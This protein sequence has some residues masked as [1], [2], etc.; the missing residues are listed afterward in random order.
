[1]FSVRRKAE[2]ILYMT[3]F[4]LGLLI[5][6]AGCKTQRQITVVSGKE[7]VVSCPKKAAP[8]AVVNIETVSVTDA[9][10]YVIVDGEEI[11]CEKEGV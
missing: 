2:T 4:L 6:S 3:V 5:G 1:M 11:K 10:L 8:G 9:D 7:H